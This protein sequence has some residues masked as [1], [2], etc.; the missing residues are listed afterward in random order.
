MKSAAQK[1][2]PVKPPEHNCHCS[3]RPMRSKRTQSWYA[4]K[5]E[6]AKV[7]EGGQAGSHKLAW[8]EA[9]AAGWRAEL[10]KLVAAEGRCAKARRA[11]QASMPSHA[12]GGETDPLKLAAAKPEPAKAVAPA[13]VVAAAGGGCC[14]AGCRWRNPSRRTSRRRSSRWW[15]RLAAPGPGDT[16]RCWAIRDAQL[17]FVRGD[18]QQALAMAL[19][20]R[21]RGGEDAA[22]ARVSSAGLR[23]NR[24]AALATTAYRNLKSPDA[25][26]TLI[27]SGQRKR[28]AVRGWAV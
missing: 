11:S 27:D 22:S 5:P 14:R 17:A 1:A 10:A 7:V 3:R 2:E 20:S 25:R 6:P 8:R 9:G 12:G 23:S 15:L 4:I 26:K 13:V 24:Q 16:R 21:G 28:R 18:R 19:P